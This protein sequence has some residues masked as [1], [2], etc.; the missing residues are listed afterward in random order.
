MLYI[1]W[2]FSSGSGRC[3]SAAFF[4]GVQLELYR[5]RIGSFVVRCKMMRKGNVKCQAIGN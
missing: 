2:E 3:V 4:V 5:K 1:K